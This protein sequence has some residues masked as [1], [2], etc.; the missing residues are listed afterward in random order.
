MPPGF[1]VPGLDPRR[2]GRALMTKSRPPQPSPRQ[3]RAPS[4]RVVLERHQHFS[5]SLLWD[6]QRRYFAT[7]GIAAWSESE[8]PHY[9]TS[10]IVLAQAYAEIVFASWRDGQRAAGPASQPLTIL[11]LGAG[12]GRLAFHFLTELRGLCAAQGVPPTAFRYVLSDHSRANFEF[13]RTHPQFQPFFA[14]GLL[15]LAVCDINEPG[16]IRLEASGTTLAPGDLAQ[17]LVVVANYV[18]DSVPQDLYHLEKGRCA[19]VGV[20]LT[21][22][23]PTP[24][25]PGELLRHVETE[26]SL[27]PGLPG[28]AA[29]CLQELLEGYTR[30]LDRTYLLFPTL[31]LQCLDHLARFSP[32][33]LLLLSADKGTHRLKD[34]E[35]RL[36]PALVRHGSFSLSVNY[37]AIKMLC[38]RRGGV[39]LF[40]PGRHDSVAVSCCLMLAGAR[41]YRETQCAYRRHVA[42]FGPD[43]YYGITLHSR[44]HIA[45]MTV[46]DILAYLRLSRHDAHQ[47]ARYLP[48]LRELAPDFTVRD[49]DAVLAAIA[50]VWDRYFPIG[51]GLNIAG[52]I[53]ALLCE[54]DDCER[55]LHYF[56]H[57]VRL[58]G[59]TPD[60]LAL[61]AACLQTLGRETEASALL[62]GAEFAPPA[63]ELAAKA[64]SF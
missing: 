48:R 13:W 44:Q 45:Q 3:R 1:R 49:R 7:R 24:T 22:P 19:P 16:P 42:E 47:F 29:P 8:V 34:L 39:A 10:N 11:E 57:A 61:M 37:H 35:G 38:E 21:L 32:R 53:A 23:H 28:P 6:W 2:A 9:V 20:S 17:P 40:P 62:N 36:P 46:R 54:M 27:L 59:A 18:F 25:D 31:A 14:E 63:P 50:R 55:A 33:G 26:F 51:E 41:D 4:P 12:C 58:H 60:M 52:E 56:T 64:A 5:R 43:D 30:A 15:D